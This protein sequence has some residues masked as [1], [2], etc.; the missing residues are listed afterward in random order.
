MGRGSDG[1]CHSFRPR[2]QSCPHCSRLLAVG[3][4]GEG[5]SGPRGLGGGHRLGAALALMRPAQPRAAAAAG[6]P[7]PRPAVGRGA[8]GLWAPCLRSTPSSCRRLS[9]FRCCRALRLLHP[10]GQAPPAPRPSSS[11]SPQPGLRLPPPRPP[12]P[13][14]RPR[15]LRSRRSGAL[16]SHAPSRRRARHGRCHG[17]HRGHP[18]L[19]CRRRGRW[20][21]AAEPSTR[22]PPNSCSWSR[23]CRTEKEISASVR[24]GHSGAGNRGLGEVGRCSGPG[25]RELSGQ[26]RAGHWVVRGAS[27][28][29]GV[30][31]GLG[32][33]GGRP[34]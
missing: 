14:P 29:G 7:G 5:R 26:G 23:T 33:A 32:R 12:P 24:T 4:G 8:C 13:P 11:S 16:A 9:P 2:G 31:S 15:A 34:A 30:G 27:P 22:R 19:H 10:P 18:W 17:P 6:R 25:H 20:P 28:A 1:R 3:R 21:L